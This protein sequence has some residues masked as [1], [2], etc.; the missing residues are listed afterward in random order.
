M[1]DV[2]IDIFLF[3]Y[4]YRHFLV[5]KS[6]LTTESLNRF[7]DVKTAFQTKGTGDPRIS[8]LFFLVLQARL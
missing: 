7:K 1:S 8:W 4:K 6:R 5:V 3:G 2:K